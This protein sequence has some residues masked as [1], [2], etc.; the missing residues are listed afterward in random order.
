MFVFLNVFQCY[1]NFWDV[2]KAF[3]NVFEMFSMFLDVP[4]AF[5]L[6]R[7]QTTMLS[8][9]IPKQ[10]SFSIAFSHVCYR[11]PPQTNRP[12]T[13]AN[14]FSDR[15]SSLQPYEQLKQTMTK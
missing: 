10:S 6:S 4:L 13:H 7:T 14:N 5:I 1:K 2:S 8:S 3:S 15:D 12:A 9:S 11:F